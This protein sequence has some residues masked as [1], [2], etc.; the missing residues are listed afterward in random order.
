[1]KVIPKSVRFTEDVNLLQR[2]R[3]LIFWYGKERSIISNIIIITQ[4]GLWHIISKFVKITKNKNSIGFT[5]LYYSGNPRSVF[6]WSLQHGKSNCYWIARNIKTFSFLKKLGI[7]KVIYAYSLIGMIQ[8][9][10]MKVIVT[11][12]S[13]LTILFPQNKPAYIQLWHGIGP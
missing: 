1:M 13:Y 3:K 5:A 2:A 11:A 7:E 12:D 10:S 9:T 6:E 8:L 4:I